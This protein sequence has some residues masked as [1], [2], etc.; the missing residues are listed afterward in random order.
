MDDSVPRPSCRS[1]VR[2]SGR[3]E[4]R[5]RRPYA[6]FLGDE[7][8]EA[9]AHCV[10]VRGDRE[11]QHADREFRAVDRLGVEQ[12]AG[13][14]P[15]READPDGQHH[16]GREQRPEERLPAV[17]EGVSL[18]ARPARAAVARDQEERS[19]RVSNPLRHLGEDHCAARE[20]RD[21]DVRRDV[22]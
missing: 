9:Q 1:A 21:H 11:R 2:T 22:E 18:I 4:L 16:E 10:A 12:A 6:P 20:Q 14:T 8:A 17:A 7:L 15:G 5:K 13:A 19:E 3:R